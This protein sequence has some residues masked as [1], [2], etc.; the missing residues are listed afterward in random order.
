[1]QCLFEQ[2]S[3]ESPTCC[4]SSMKS[5]QI[6]LGMLSVQTNIVIVTGKTKEEILTLASIPK[7]D[8][9]GHIQVKLVCCLKHTVFQVQCTKS[10][11]KD[12]DINKGTGH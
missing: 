5:L 4:A 6:V 7:K 3:K 8:L 10:T 2:H 1:M 11:V 12:V 9:K